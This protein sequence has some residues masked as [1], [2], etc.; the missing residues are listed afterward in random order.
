MT[1]QGLI[2]D[3]INGG[4]NTFDDLNSLELA[5]LEKKKNMWNCDF[6]FY[7]VVKIFDF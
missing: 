4:R 6:Y 5:L 1:D 7:I 3:W 2:R